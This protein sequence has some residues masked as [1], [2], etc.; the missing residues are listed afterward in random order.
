MNWR[1]AV[2]HTCLSQKLITCMYRMFKCC[3]VLCCTICQSCICV[4]EYVT[5]LTRLLKPPLP[6][7]LIVREIVSTK[8]SCTGLMHSR[9][10][11]NEDGSSIFLHTRAINTLFGPVQLGYC[12]CCIYFPAYKL[13]PTCH[14]EDCRV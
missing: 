8:R 10:K 13:Y 4:L 11:N 7:S 1:D 9:K 5:D 2:C 3:I 6:T 14:F 12:C